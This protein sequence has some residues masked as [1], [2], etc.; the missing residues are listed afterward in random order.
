MAIPPPTTDTRDA[1][2]SRAWIPELLSLN[3]R[4]EDTTR[5]VAY[6]KLGLPKVG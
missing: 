6:A 5:E 2:T 4:V 1:S 3:A